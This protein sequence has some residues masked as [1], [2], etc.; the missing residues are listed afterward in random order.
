FDKTPLDAARDAYNRVAEKYG[1]EK[2]EEGSGA[3]SYLQGGYDRFAKQ[4]DD[5]GSYLQGYVGSKGRPSEPAESEMSAAPY[6]P[7]GQ[8]NE[9]PV[10]AGGE[11]SNA[12]AASASPE[13]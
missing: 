6:L 4:S 8:T 9:H 11:V 5:F 13:V 3:I 7:L 10:Y 12:D 1:F 2:S